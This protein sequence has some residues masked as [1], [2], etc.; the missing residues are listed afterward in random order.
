MGNGRKLGYDA[1]R[2]TA[3][4]M[5]VMIHVSAYVVTYFRTTDN[6][7]FVVGNIFN[8]LGRAGTP[9]F[10]M[11]TGALL[12]DE[13]RP[14]ASRA[15]YRKNLLSIC[16]L[17]VFW[18]FFYATWRAVALRQLMGKPADMKLFLDYLLTLRGRFPHLW[19][20]FML[21]GVYILIPVLRLIVRKENKDYVLGLIVLSVIVQF[22]V[23]TLGVFTEGAD[24]TLRDFADKFHM[25]YA[26]G[27]IA[28]VLIGWYLTTFPPQ[29]KMRAVLI[30]SGIAALVFIILI[31]QFEIDAV[32]TIRD[33]MVEMNTLPALIYGVGLFTFITTHYGERETKSGAVAMLSQQA[34]GIYMIH[35]LILDILINIALPY[36]AFGERA[37]VLYTL[38]VFVL[39]FGFSLL[40]SLC[41]SRIPV[42]KRIVRG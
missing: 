40:I 39:D 4:F 7:T 17:L 34:F 42:V 15:F 24:F 27:Y 37:P 6:A 13:R 10:L 8:G 29:G 19:Y 21:I 2:I 41:L 31:V 16:L 38:V 22:A 26:T 14:V 35:V 3:V 30:G 25:E 11:L 20:M 28:Y 12:L 32:P 5:I 33:Y 1:V 23:Q 9:L 36:S 18:L